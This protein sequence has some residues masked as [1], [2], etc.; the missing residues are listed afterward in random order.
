MKTLLLLLFTLCSFTARAAETLRVMTFNLRYINSGD[1]GDKAWTARRDASAELIKKDAPDFL[2]TQEAFRVMLDDV[3]ARVPGYAEIGVGREDGKTKGEYAAILYREAA[4]EMKES[5]TFWLSDTPEV[6][7]SSSWGNKVTRICTWGKFRS[8]ATGGEV[9]VFNA[10][11]DHESQPAREKGAALILKRIV[12]RGSNAPVIVMGDFNAAPDN[13]AMKTMVQGPPV[14]TDVWAARH[15]DAKT[16]ESGTFHGFEGRRDG[17]RIDYIL[18]TA[19]WEPGEAAILNE[20]KDGK[21]PSDHY[22]V[23]AT[24]TLKP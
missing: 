1:R 12:E 10:H 3:K 16:A 22:P 24:L 14:L 9:F 19:E 20:A 13:A 15:K 8:K 6:V 23:R 5:G 11:L 18:T 4:W 21:W 2:G 7:A 17:A